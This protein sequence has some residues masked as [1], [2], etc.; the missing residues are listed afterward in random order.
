MQVGRISRERKEA[1][2][3][4]V[5]EERD[6]EETRGRSWQIVGGGLSRAG[7]AGCQGSGR[8]SGGGKFQSLGI[9]TG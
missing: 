4:R 1:V 2:K 8:R 5:R 7:M 9:W 6:E 3:E